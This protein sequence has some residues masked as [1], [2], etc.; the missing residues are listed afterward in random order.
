[1]WRCGQLGGGGG[2]VVV[3]AGIGQNT[4][5]YFVVGHSEYVE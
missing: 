5:S 2:D 4:T 3:V 1:M